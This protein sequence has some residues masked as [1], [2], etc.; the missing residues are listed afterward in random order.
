MKTDLYI[1]VDGGATKTIV[2][3]EDS[4][5]RVLGKGRGGSANIRHSVEN[6]WQS[7]LSAIAMALEETGIPLGDERYNWLCGAG[8]AGSQVPEAVEAFVN[9]PHPLTHLVVESDGY[10]SC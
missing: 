2:R 7:I 8:I 10:I 3:I 4:Q 1:G 9:Y 5:G 6:T